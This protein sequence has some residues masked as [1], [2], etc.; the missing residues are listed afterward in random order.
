MKKEKKNKMVY[1]R[2]SSLEYDNFITICNNKSSNLSSGLREAISDYIKKNQD[3]LFDVLFP[4][5][6]EIF[7]SKDICYSDVGCSE[8]NCPYYADCDNRPQT[9]YWRGDKAPLIND[10]DIK[11]LERKIKLTKINKLNEEE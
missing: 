3:D 1:T 4:E 8:G 11:Q 2:L 10:G 9:S 5:D 7:D 6:I